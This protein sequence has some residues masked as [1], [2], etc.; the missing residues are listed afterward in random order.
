MTRVTVNSEPRDVAASTLGEL[1]R[2]LDLGDAKVATALNGI[3][4]PVGARHQMILKGNDAVEI[5][6]PMSGG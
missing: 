3:F 1:V 5:V 2:E 4:V 6:A